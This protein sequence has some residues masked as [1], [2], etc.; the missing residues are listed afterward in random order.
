MAG[1][2]FMHRVISYVV[3]ELVVNSLANR[4]WLILLI[5]YPPS[6]LLLW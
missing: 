5:S 4:Y 6:I 2:N 3:N 1:G